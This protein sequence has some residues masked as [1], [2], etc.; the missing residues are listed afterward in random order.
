MFVIFE[1]NVCILLLFSFNTSKILL[2]IK[3]SKDSVFLGARVIVA[4]IIQ[5]KDA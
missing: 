3:D 1:Y 2:S 5:A 4:V